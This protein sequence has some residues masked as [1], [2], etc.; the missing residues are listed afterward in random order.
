MKNKIL[1]FLLLLTI[2]INAQEV[3]NIQT[4][5][6][7]QTE[8]PALT[9][10]KM[11]QVETGFSYEKT[12]SNESSFIIPSVLW[13]YGVSEN[14]ELRLVTEFTYNK[15][16]SNKNSGINPILVGFKA[17]LI[18]E[19]G[20]IPKT[21]FI[22]HIALPNISSTQYKLDYLAPQFRFAMQHTLSNKVSISY[23]LGSEWN[24]FTPEPTFIYTLATGYSI[25]EKIGTYIE[26][27]GFAPQNQKSNHNFDGG[28]TY[29][30]SN[31]MMVDVS[32]GIGLTK[33]APKHYYAIG[34]SFRI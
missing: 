18:E 23:N 24:G 11:L 16:Y 9:P 14:F 6:P 29:F 21:S 7:D 5:R 34:F 4:D 27:F 30:L 10:L 12:N 31:D 17:R 20:I 1:L 15:S 19:N 3:E 2:T 8:T 33:N 28:F 26:V 13:K 25:S 32:G 22:G